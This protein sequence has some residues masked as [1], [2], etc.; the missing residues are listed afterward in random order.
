MSRRLTPGRVLAGIVVVVALTA[1]I[2]W[3]IP[4]D[5]YILLVDTAHPVAPFVTVE[6][7][8]RE[9]G[10]GTVYYVDVFERRA[11][12]LEALIPWLHSHATLVPAEDI[13]SPCA[14]AAEEEAAQQQEM[15]SSQQIGAAVA[16]RRLGYHVGVRP[17]GVVVSQLYAGTNAPCNLQPT[18]VIVAVNGNPTPTIAS[19][20]RALNTVK[21][22]DVV[23][24]RVRRGRRPLTVRLKTVAT[25]ADPGHAFIGIAA[26]QSARIKLPI[27]VSIDLPRVGGPSAGLA[28]ALEVMERL[29]KNITH[30][31]RVAATGEMEL[32]GAVGPI[33]GV[34]QKTFGARKAGADVFLVPAGGGNAREARRYAGSLRIIPVHTFGQALRALATLSKAQ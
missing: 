27:R 16:L 32:D 7:A 10:G 20:H 21:P 19:L 28:F 31:Y 29:G 14:T 23:S 8:K 33:G 22:G 13:L 2:L 3:R 18:D 12:E 26:D 17:N 4:S 1:L 5:K 30:G 24:L 25:A 9:A 11:R 6:G 15:L 34:E